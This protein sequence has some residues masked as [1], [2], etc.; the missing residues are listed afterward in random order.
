M[1]KP[2]ES[3]DALHRTARIMIVDDEP[4]NIRVAR[5]Y[6]Q[7]AGYERFVTTTELPDA[8]KMIREQQPDIILLDMNM[9]RMD[10]LTILQ[11]IRARGPSSTCRS[12]FLPRIPIPRPSIE[13]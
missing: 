2:E 11:A 3:L 13:R 1:V 10:G 9:P 8:F 7:A 5:K 4:L 12:S 6:L